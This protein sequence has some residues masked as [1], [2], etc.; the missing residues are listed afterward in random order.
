MKIKQNLGLVDRILR[1]GISSFM[2]YLGFFEQDIV[3]DEIAT[4]ILAAFGTGIL[5]SAIIGNC[6]LYE[7]IGLSTCKADQYNNTENNNH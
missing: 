3:V 1:I 6:P 4:M 2:V 7:V 5:I